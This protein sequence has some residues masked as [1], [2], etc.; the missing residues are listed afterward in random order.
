MPTPG[1]D[2][3]AWHDLGAQYPRGYEWFY[4]DLME[5]DGTHLSVSLLAPNPFDLSPFVDMPPISPRCPQCAPPNVPAPSRHVGVAVHASVPGEP[6]NFRSAQEFIHL[7]DQDTR[8]SFQ[9]DPWMLRVG[10]ATVRRT[11]A[12]LPVYTLDFDVTAGP[13]HAAGSLTFEAIQPEWMVPEDGLLLQQQ[14]DA[15]HWHR[16]AVLAP[17]TTVSGDYEINAA[18]PNA[19]PLKKQLV[20]ADGYHDHNWGTRSPAAAFQRWMWAR[21][22]AAENAVVA[23]S[24]VPATATG[25][26][27]LRVSSIFAVMGAAGVSTNLFRVVPAATPAALPFAHVVDI[28]YSPSAGAYRAVFEHERIALEFASSYQRRIAK[29]D[30]YD[31]AGG[32]PAEGIAVT[33]TMLPVLVP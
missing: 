20:T 28:G 33:E 31:P 5:G 3:R 10:G 6:P 9:A 27:D 32:G 14:T 29:L 22:S 1:N 7:N 4:F 15:D 2:V 25:Y 18:D 8:L 19:P 12:A 21:G 26:T 24:I 16:W 11:N 30:L 17:R 13:L 23:A